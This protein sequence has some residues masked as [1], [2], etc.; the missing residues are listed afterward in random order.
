LLFNGKMEIDSQ[1]GNGT[2]IIINIPYEKV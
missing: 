1:K 2:N